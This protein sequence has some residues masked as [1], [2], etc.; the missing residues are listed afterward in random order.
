MAQAEIRTRAWAKLRNMVSLIDL[1]VPS[2]KVPRKTN[3]LASVEMGGMLTFLKTEPSI[4]YDGTKV[5]GV[6]LS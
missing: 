3:L 1:M 2:K 4:H 5:D 6:L